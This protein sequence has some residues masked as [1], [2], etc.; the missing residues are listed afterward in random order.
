VN[1]YINFNKEKDRFRG[2]FREPSPEKKKT[3]AKTQKKDK[4]ISFTVPIIFTL[5]SI[6]QSTKNICFKIKIVRK[7]E[8]A[9]FRTR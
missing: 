7:K 6:D 5:Q 4:I 2:Y 3:I 1:K 9:I 8:H